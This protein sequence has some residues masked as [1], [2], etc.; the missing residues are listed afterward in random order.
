MRK[1]EALDAHLERAL[2][3]IGFWGVSDCVLWPADWVVASGWPDPA[4]AF[5][6]RYRTALGAAR[7]VARAGG[8]QALWRAE[9][10]RLGLAETARPIAG[11]VGLALRDTQGVGPALRGHVGAVCLGGGEWACRTRGGLRT[12]RW[13]IVQAWRVSWRTR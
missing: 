12:G 11:D 1:A 8:L 13:P 9:A 10:A 3:D 6:G 5:R 2:T 7:I 4:E